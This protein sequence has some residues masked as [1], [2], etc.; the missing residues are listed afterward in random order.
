MRNCWM[1]QGAQALCSGAHGA[2]HVR[3]G[4]LAQLSSRDCLGHVRLGPL[5]QL[6][7][8]DRIALNT[9]AM[10]TWG[11]NTQL[12]SEAKGRDDSLDQCIF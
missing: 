1:T 2:G 3:L 10:C 12:F 11:P 7:S 5:A 4:P 6:S 8:R 9:N